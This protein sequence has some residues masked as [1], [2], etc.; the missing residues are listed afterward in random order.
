MSNYDSKPDIVRQTQTAINAAGYTPPLV[1][2]GTYGPHTKAGVVWFQGQHGLSQD[3]IIGDQTVAAT[4]AAPP[5]AAVLPATPI[6]SMP[7]T[8]VNPI[9][10]LQSQLSQLQARAAAVL[11]PPVATLRGPLVLRG[12][13]AATAYRGPAP[14]VQPVAVV[15]SSSSPASG[16]TLPALL[17]TAAGAAVGALFSFPIGAAAGAAAGLIAGLAYGK[18]AQ[19][20]MHGES[21][22]GFDLYDLDRYDDQLMI[23]AGEIGVPARMH[24]LKE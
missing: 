15:P 17:G 13:A 5:G 20:T 21:D 14:G 18:H 1:V 2:D 10:S 6:F 22:F 3:G 23:V 9:A 24:T 4:I 12:L 11:V 16:V 8:G 19:S 7:P